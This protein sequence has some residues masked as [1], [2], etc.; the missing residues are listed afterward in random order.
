MRFLR[1]KEV[2]LGLGLGGFRLL[3]FAV[4][5]RGFSNLVDGSI[6]VAFETLAQSALGVCFII[7][8]AL[9]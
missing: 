2:G 7:S 9:S 1:V 4:E 5:R 8:D 3:G 6:C